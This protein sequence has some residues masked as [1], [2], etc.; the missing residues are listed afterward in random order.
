M[1]YLDPIPDLVAPAVVAIADQLTLSQAPTY[2]EYVC[3]GLTAVGYIAGF[4]G[5]GGA[6]VKNLGIASL[7]LTVRHLKTRLSTGV[8]GVGRTMSYRPA[9]VGRAI[10]QTTVPEYGDVR[11]S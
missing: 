1:K 2:N 6:F 9:G 3:Y 4:L 8:T 10:G 11:V 7:P 5:F